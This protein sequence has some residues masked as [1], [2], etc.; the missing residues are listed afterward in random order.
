VNGPSRRPRPFVERIP[1]ED[2]AEPGALLDLADTG[3]GT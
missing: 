2:R 1:A 3:D